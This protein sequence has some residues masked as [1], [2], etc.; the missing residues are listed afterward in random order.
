MLTRLTLTRMRPRCGVCSS[1]VGLVPAAEEEP[2]SV[3][4]TTSGG[5]VVDAGALVLSEAGAELPD[6]PDEGEPELDLVLRAQGGRSDWACARGCTD[7]ALVNATAARHRRAARRAERG[8][9]RI[10]Y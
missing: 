10:G 2:D 6:E 1:G 3:G 7:F 8:V 5:G 4:F 9:R